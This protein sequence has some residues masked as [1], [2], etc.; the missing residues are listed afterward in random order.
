MALEGRWAPVDLTDASGSEFDQVTLAPSCVLD[1]IKYCRLT[2]IPSANR[3][4]GGAR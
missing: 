3:V 4:N 2:W 1:L